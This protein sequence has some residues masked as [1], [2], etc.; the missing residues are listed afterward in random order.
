MAQTYG[1][2]GNILSLKEQG[3]PGAS[4][5]PVGEMPPGGGHWITPDPWRYV[6]IQNFLS[7]TYYWTF[8]EALRDS[9]VCNTDAMW[10]DPIINSAI[11]ERQRPVVQLDYQF[12]ERDSTDPAQKNLAK[13][14]TEIFQDVPGFQQMRR[15]LLDA[16][17]WGRAGVELVYAWDR[18]LGDKRLRVRQWMPI[19][20][21]SLV[22]KFDG[23]V[24]YLVN[25]LRAREPGVQ[26]IENRS[27]H[28]KFFSA[29]EEEA[30]LIH[31]FEPQP[32][33]FFRP[34]MAGAVH[35]TGYR[36]RVYWYW[37]LKQN[38]MR[39][40]MNFAK[41]AG[42]GFFKAGYAAGN[43]N[44]LNNMRKALEQQGENNIIYVPISPSRTLK[45]VLE[46]MPVSLQGADFQWGV[47][48]GLNA[49]IRDAIL[50][51]SM[52]NKAA[53]AGIGGSN[54][55]HMGIA[56]DERVK[57]DAV[58]LETPI[59]KMVNVISRYIAPGVRPPRFQHLADKRQPQEIAAA[60]QAYMAAGGVIGS[61]WFQS[62]LGIPEPEKD[63]P[64]LSM[65]QAQQ[66]AALNAVP[67]G[68]PMAGQP[69]PVDQGQ[70]GA[71]GMD[72]DTQAL[73]S[74]I[75]PMQAMR[76]LF[77]R[78]IH[79]ARD[80]SGDAVKMAEELGARFGAEISRAMQAH[81]PVVNITVPPTPVSLD[82]KTPEVVVNPTFNTS[83]PKVDFS[84]SHED[85]PTVIVDTTNL[86]NGELASHYEAAL[87]ELLK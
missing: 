53:P 86:K 37:W 8:D 15:C 72:Q 27:G 29:D 87:R 85:P 30:V 33:D 19:H 14:M 62:E 34:E 47:I 48:Q 68:E 43:V 51:N 46:H 57:Y 39:I 6:A 18:S 79:L 61:R 50:G 23:G 9:G 36:G 76:D 42:N 31:E 83:P 77:D 21:D 28:A 71:G 40:M 4:P 67:A 82:I 20:G 65:I 54:A 44:E 59:Q 60:A 73:A 55:D 5:S 74:Q 11:R 84:L 1:G 32:A 64:T 17:W 10:S 35:G 41:K 2:H 52:T 12:E 22:F 49:Y 38:L 70:G 45:D 75:Q 81:N 26:I 7:H 66:P 58:D 24:G 69:G 25:A 80:R 63:E 16:L 56:D 78:T 13:I 3:Y